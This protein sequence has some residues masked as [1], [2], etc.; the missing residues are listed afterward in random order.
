MLSVDKLNKT[1]K[2][3]GGEVHAVRDVSFH[4]GDGE[5]VAIIG[6]SGS[7]KSTLLSLL[8]LLDAPD[9]GS[10]D[11]NGTQLAHLDSSGRTKYRSRQVGFVFQAFNLIPN[12]TAK[13]NV[14]LA[15]EFAEW[16]RESRNARAEEMLAMVGLGADKA[17]RRPNK[18]SGGEQQRV[19]I[20]RAFAAQPQ[21]ILADEPTGSLDK[22]T[23]QKIVQLLREAANTQKT[24][25]LVV[26]HDERVAKQADRRLEIEDGV[27]TEIA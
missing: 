24:T 1:F 18:L 11:M 14:K 16:P 15:L 8:G 23:G 4:A 9:E 3:D 20:A 2:T 22:A 21:L 10:I 17:E 13:E 27:L 25:V 26:T 5:M 12:L 19:A 7:G 6:A